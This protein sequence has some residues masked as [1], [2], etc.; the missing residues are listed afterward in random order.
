MRNILYLLIMRRWMRSPWQLI[1]GVLGVSLGVGVVLAIDLT[2]ASALRSF[3]ISGQSIVN[4]YSHQIIGG[5]SGLDESLYRNLR[6]ALGLHKILPIVE[7]DVTVSDGGY[8]RLIG[9]DPVSMMGADAPGAAGRYSDSLFRLIAE[10]DTVFMADSVVRQL[11][12]DATGRITVFSNGR[13]RTLNLIG[14]MPARG[15]LQG[16]L[17]QSGLL[18]DIATA[19]ELLGMQGRLSRIDLTLSATEIE[20]VNSVLDRSQ[21]LILSETPVHAMAQMTRAFRINLTALSLLAL[22]IGAFLIYNTMTISVLQRREQFAVLRILGTDQDEILYLVISEA[23]VV[24]LLGILSGY[25]LG[26]G[27]SQILIRLASRTMIDLY[28]VSEVQHLYVNGWS[29]IRATALGLGGVLAAAYLPARDAMTTVPLLTRSRSRLEQQARSGQGRLF[30]YS[31]ASAGFA[32]MILLVTDRNIIAGFAA[33]FFIII[34]FALASPLLLI[35]I[36]RIFKPVLERL[37]GLPGLIAARG[38]LASLSRTRVAVVALAVAISATIGVSIMI[39]SF[40]HSVETWLLNYLKADVYISATARG[41]D[42][43]IGDAMLQQLRS[44]PGVENT[45]TACYRNIRNQDKAARI[46]VVDIDKQV[47]TA[48]P[49][50][51]D[52]SPGQWLK[53]SNA[54]G[55]LIS[56]PYAYHNRVQE[57]DYLTLTTDAGVHRFQVIGIYVD[58]G[59]DQGVITMHRDIYSK[60]WQDAPVTSVALYIGT[61]FNAETLAQMLN[62]GLLRGSDLHARANRALRDQS[63]RIFDR[64]FSITQVLRILTVICAV[65]GIFGALMSIQLE[66]SREFAVLRANGLTPAGLRQLIL[67]EAGLMGVAAGMIA[68]PL[69]ILLAAVLIYVINRRSFGWTMDFILE[70]RYLVSAV[71]LGLIA[72]VLAGVYPAWRM[73]EVRP[74]TALRDE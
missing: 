39:G 35:L 26:I 28:F 56:E 50:K 38:V 2:N 36:V 11:K 67:S 6:T 46:R 41:G 62:T 7:G 69:G 65:I 45:T 73:G 49:F 16:Q 21:Q 68:L 43:P 23:L 61:S 70:P 71:L 10:P 25:A 32:V 18:T 1:L 27:L 31:I 24:A 48:Y 60:Y 33:L 8:Y 34:S 9:I 51:H 19:Q 15:N 37:I 52:V 42:F 14:V 55:V 29:F 13:R 4:G 44:L 22:V 20:Q 63:M 58:Y 3:E 66:R 40:R 74:A 64:T 72:G 17:L 47:F 54:A 30:M 53:F 12:P 59:S 57:G 5:T